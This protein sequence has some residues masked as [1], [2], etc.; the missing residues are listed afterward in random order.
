MEKSYHIPFHGNNCSNHSRADSDAGQN[1]GQ[2]RGSTRGTTRVAPI[3]TP[4][5][6]HG[7]RPRFV[8]VHDSLLLPPVSGSFPQRLHDSYDAHLNYQYK[9]PLL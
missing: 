5:P 2:A 3:R 9:P 8:Q 4:Y 1:Q 6:N 7:I